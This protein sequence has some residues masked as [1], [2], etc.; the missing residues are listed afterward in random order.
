MSGFT[1]RERLELA[2]NANYWDKARVPK[3]DKML[4]LPMPEA[5]ARTAALLSG[6]LDWIE[7]P[8]PDAVAEIKQRR[9]L[10]RTNEEPPIWSCHVSRVE[11]SPCNDISLRHP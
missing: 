6:Q 5:N 3:V 8:A 11:S 9:F 4:L 1:P 10:L 2:K 7:A